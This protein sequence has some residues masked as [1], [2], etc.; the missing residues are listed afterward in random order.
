MM[1]QTHVMVCN[2]FWLS[3]HAAN[4]C[5]IVL[6]LAATNDE[7]VCNSLVSKFHN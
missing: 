4:T 6:L 5:N 3:V 2:F 7:H 1:D